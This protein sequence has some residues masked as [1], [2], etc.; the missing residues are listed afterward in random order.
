MNFKTHPANSDLLCRP[1]KPQSHQTSPLHTTS[2]WLEYPDM[3]KLLLILMFAIVFEGC[4]K[5][6]ASSSDWEIKETLQTKDAKGEYTGTQP[7]TVVFKNGYKLEGLGYN[8]SVVGQWPTVGPAKGYFFRSY[9]CWECEPSLELVA[10]STE[11]KTLQRLAYPGTQ[12]LEDAVG[13]Q[14]G[15]YDAYRVKSYTGECGPYSAVS[16]HESRESA[17]AKFEMKKVETLVLLASGDLSLLEKQP[18][19]PE[20]PKLMESL[21]NSKCH[22]LPGIDTS[23]YL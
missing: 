4:F 6:G 1:H 10:F 14:G 12:H 16:I 3:G 13:D 5:T 23:D 2:R 15:S 7:D 19:D 21:S 9:T 20:L 11:K 22:A 18:K 17:S 8:I